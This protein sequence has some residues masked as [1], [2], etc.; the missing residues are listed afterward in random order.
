MT[1][2]LNHNASLLLSVSLA[3][4]GLIVAVARFKL[5]SFIALVLASLF[6][7]L[8][9]EMPLTDIAKSFQE[10]VG[11]TLGSIAV[12][13][14]LGMMLGKMLAESGGAEIVASTFV[15]AFGPSRL[16]WAMAAIAF[17]IGLPVFFAVGLVLLM[18]ILL[19]LARESRLP[20]LYLGLPMVAGLAVS[21]TLVP[22]HP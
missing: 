15:R 2:P 5:N 4:I 16:P 18:P 12:V 6:V 10:G 9:S 1:W 19:N 13:V 8:R 3:V 14:G 20:L 7:G 17:I 22:P 11:G 21:H